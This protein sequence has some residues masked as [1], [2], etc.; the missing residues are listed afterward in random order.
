MS[1]PQPTGE[2][3]GSGIN[4]ESAGNPPVVV[5][6]GNATP[7]EI[8]AVSAVVSGLLAE[9]GEAR[10]ESEPAGTTAWQRSQRALRSPLQP[11]PGR[12]NG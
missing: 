2:V 5:T 10:R 12:W 6:T 1:D 8:A 7:A 3:Y 4:P 11:G 9:E